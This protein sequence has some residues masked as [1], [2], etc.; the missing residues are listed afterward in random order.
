MQL[1][2]MTVEKKTAFT[3]IRLTETQKDQLAKLKKQAGVS[4]SKALATALDFWLP[5]VLAGEIPPL[6]PLQ[7][8]S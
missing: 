1:E 3:Q 6:P 5:R 7:K 2:Q 4:R 8:E